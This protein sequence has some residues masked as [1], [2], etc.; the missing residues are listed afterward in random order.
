ML[1][2]YDAGMPWV[3]ATADFC[4]NRAKSRGFI[5][6][7]GGYK[8]RFS[9]EGPPGAN[10]RKAFNR[11]CQASGAIQNKRAMVDAHS[12]GVKLRLTMHDEN[13]ASGDEK[14]GKTLVECMVNSFATKLVIPFRV[15]HG[16]GKSWGEAS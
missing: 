6:L 3:K 16:I 4:E 1:D 9:E 14:A 11:V 2:E 5:R 8:A 10:P 15:D 13:G 7:I 12:M